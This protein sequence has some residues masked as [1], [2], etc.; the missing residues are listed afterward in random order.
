MPAFFSRR[1]GFPTPFV[2]SP[3]TSLYVAG[4]TLA[5][6]PPGRVFAAPWQSRRG[7]AKTERKVMKKRSIQRN[8]LVFAKETIRQL[9]PSDLLNVAGGISC[10]HPTNTACDCS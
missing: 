10:A 7:S 3:N 1:D 4:H 2:A 5:L 6:F 8:K 9:V